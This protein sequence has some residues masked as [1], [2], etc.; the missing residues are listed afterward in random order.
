MM[1]SFHF[2]SGFMLGIEFVQDDEEG[3]VIL[4]LDLGILR[5]TA[6]RFRLEED[7]G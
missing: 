5:V 4:V 6:Q 2:I 7:E 3:T 1:F